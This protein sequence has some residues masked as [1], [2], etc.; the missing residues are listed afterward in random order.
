[1]PG[2]VLMIEVATGDAV[3]AGQR[4]CVVEAMKMEHS[5][6]A[7]FDGIVERVGAAVGTSV[8]L[9]TEIVRVVVPGGSEEGSQ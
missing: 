3:V 9:G 2:T 5:L 7:P 4:L 8:A 1:M 6:V